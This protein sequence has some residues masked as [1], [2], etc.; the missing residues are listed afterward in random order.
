[1]SAVVLPAGLTIF[2]AE[3]GSGAGGE[4]W[5][6]EIAE[7]GEAGQGARWNRRRLVQVPFEKDDALE[8]LAAANLVLLPA[9]E[10]RLLELCY[11][12]GK[13]LSEAAREMGFR[14]S[15]ASR[16]HARALATLRTAIQDNASSSYRRRSSGNDRPSA[17]RHA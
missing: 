2:H 5:L 11:Y 10:R 3:Q 15:W 6:A 12:Q 8:A 1:R 14:R 9:R 7:G 4:D 13:T 16:L 17:S